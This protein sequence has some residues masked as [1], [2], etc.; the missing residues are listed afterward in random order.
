MIEK[1]AARS[2]PR[3]ITDYCAA[4]VFYFQ[5]ILKFLFSG[6]M[7]ATVIGNLDP[8]YLLGPWYL[9]KNRKESKLKASLIVISI[10]FLYGILQLIVFPNMSI[11]KLAVTLLKLAVCILCMLYVMENAEKINFLRIAKIISVFMELRF[12]SRYFLIRVLCFGLPTI[13]SI[14]TPRHGFGCFIMNQVN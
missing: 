2:K 9:W 3:R 13:M 10:F 8:W 6:K 14:N 11:L 12:H 5:H 4:L 7:I 1:T